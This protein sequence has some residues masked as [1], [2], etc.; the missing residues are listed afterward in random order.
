MYNKISLGNQSDHDFEINLPLNQAVF[1][2]GHKAPEVNLLVMIFP[3][4]GVKNFFRIINHKK[5]ASLT[6]VTIGSGQHRPKIGR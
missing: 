1:W 4:P 6:L 3:N 2:S 5:I